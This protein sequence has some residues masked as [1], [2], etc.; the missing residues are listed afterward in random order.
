MEFGGGDKEPWWL[1]C[2]CLY[3]CIDYAPILWL[4][5]FYLFLLFIYLFLERGEGKEK[6]RE[7]SINVW[8]P[9]TCPLLGAWPGPQPRHVPRLGIEPVTLWFSDSVHWATQARA[10]WLI[11]R[12]RKKGGEGERKKH[13]FVVPLIYAFTG[14][15][16]HV[17]WPEM[18]PAT[19]AYQNNT[20]TTWATQPGHGT[21]L[22][23]LFL[24]FLSSCLPVS[25]FF[26]MGQLQLT[27]SKFGTCWVWDN[28]KM[29]YGNVK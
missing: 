21:I 23:I 14:W 6:E 24:S 8:L 12:E 27:N 9:L 3:K 15:Y 13:W 10:N 20:L 11:F 7:R 28:F 29:W 25:P 26:Q 18:E 17:P 5:D 2:I 16:L 4:I 1:L 22:F 19:L